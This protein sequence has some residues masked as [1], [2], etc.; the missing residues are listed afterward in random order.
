MK[1]FSLLMGAILAL[2]STFAQTSGGPDAY[3]YT[4][5]NASH[6]GPNAPTYNWIDITTIGTQITGLGDD[7][8]VGPFSIGFPFRYYW[9]DYGQF[10]VGSNGYVG[11]QNLNISSTGTAAFPAIPTANANNN[12]LA[13]MLADLSFATP[14]PSFPN[15]GAA[16]YWSNSVDT[17]IITFQNVPFWFNN[18]A[19]WSGVN[20]FQVILSGQ[21][22]SITFQYQ[23]QIG[24]YDPAYNLSTNPVVVGIENVTGTVGL[25][26]SNNQ[27]PTSNTAVKFFYPDSVALN[28]PDVEPTWV[29]NLENGGFFVPNGSAV[30]GQA[31]VNNVGNVSLTDSTMAELTIRNNVGAMVH[32]ES[33]TLPPLMQNTGQLVSFSQGYTVSNTGS[34]FYEVETITNSDINPSNDLQVVEMVAVDTLGSSLTLSYYGGSIPLAG[35]VINWSGGDGDDGV[36]MYMEPPVY[37]L[38]IVSVDAFVFADTSTFIDTNAFEIRIYADDGP[39]GQGTLLASVFQPADS[40]LSNSWNTVHFPTPVTLNSGGFYVGWYQTGGTVQLAQELVPPFSRRSFEVL[41][42]TWSS[43][44]F[45]GSQ[46][47]LLR[48]NFQK[49]CDPTSVSFSLGADTTIC[50]GTLLTLAPGIANGAYSWSTGAMTPTLNVDSAGTFFVEVTNLNGCIG[51]DTINVGWLPSPSVD[52]GPDIVGC[53]GDTFVVAANGSFPTYAWSNGLSDSSIQV[54]NSSVLTLTVIDGN[55]CAANDNISVTITLPPQV[56][57]GPDQFGCFQQGGTVDLMT[58]LPGSYLWSN[59]S[60]NNVITISQEDT[61]WLQVTDTIGCVGSDTI[62]VTDNTPTIDLGADITGCEGTPVQ[63]D[64][65]GGFA[66]YNW[67]NGGS[68]QTTSVSMAG[69]YSVI[70]TNNTGCTATDTLAV[71]LDPLPDP[72]FSAQGGWGANWFR[73]DFTNATTG[74]T[75]YSWDFG[76]G[77]SPSTDPNPNHQYAFAGQYDVTLVATNACGSDSITISIE[78]TNTDGLEELYF[79]AVELFPNPNDGQFVLRFGTTPLQ[80]TQV[81]LFNAQ[82]QVIWQQTEAQIQPGTILNIELND[83]P[84][85]L[86]LL[87]LETE[88]VSWLQKVLVK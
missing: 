58:N 8:V 32:T 23:L 13:P 87:Q 62:G 29:N 4:W 59:G 80:Q 21:D 57:L 82:G 54:V 5:E 34:Y 27:L 67:S 50:S 19:Q 43:F 36:G 2:V 40:V 86:Y 39:P 77:S 83:P 53:L 25:M 56:N 84:A 75:S 7:N 30:T 33:Q 26:V 44:R 55:G 68:N 66:N 41:A 88:G 51:N 79:G 12:F 47:H 65:G 74:G 38:E 10:W 35:N 18:P 28:V 69:T 46:E 70:V 64:A 78:V 61:V 85:G 6:I 60:T 9:S 1:H 37:P 45:N 17:C 14:N 15:Q 31:R 81:Q 16:Y 3:G 71:M 73:W 22:S 63:L 42:N 48:V 20:S 76:D 11:F 52:L 24:I 49:A 72:N